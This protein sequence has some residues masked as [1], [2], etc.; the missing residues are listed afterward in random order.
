MAVFKKK[1]D[2][3]QFPTCPSL[4]GKDIYL[5]PAIPEDFADYQRWFLASDPQAQTCRPVQLISPEARVEK[6]RKSPDHN[7]VVHFT[8]AHKEDH[9]TVGHTTYFNLNPL[10]Q[11]AELGISIAPAERK[12][13]FATDALMTLIRH[14]F[15]E[16]DLSKVYAQTGE[17]NKA[18]RKLMESLGFKV[19]GTLR[20]H[21]RYKGELHDDLIYS[22]LQ[23]E[24]DFLK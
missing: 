7:S 1:E 17:F 11:S 5:K 15:I 8:V 24:C 21:H 20:R 19:D 10:N 22:L 9:R 14:L 2:L 3:L 23:F 18:S 13:G 12:N 16:L 4:V 6:A